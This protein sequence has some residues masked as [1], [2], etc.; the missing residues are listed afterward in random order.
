M[1][2]RYFFQLDENV[3]PL[4][5]EQLTQLALFDFQQGEIFPSQKILVLRQDHFA[6]PCPDVMKW[7]MIGYQGKRIIN[8]RMEGMDQKAIFRPWLSH[9]CAIFANGFYEWTNYRKAKE[10]IYICK[11]QENLIYLAGIYNDKGECVIVTGEAQGEM[12]RIHHRTPI[13]M[14]ECTMRNYLAQQIDFIVDNEHLAYE[15]V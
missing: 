9:R 4:L 12:T 13:I 8:A 3:S 15:K 6:Q 11:E 2:G 7:G 5:Q 10:K 1:C 14:N